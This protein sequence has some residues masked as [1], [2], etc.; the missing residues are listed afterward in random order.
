[1]KITSL[2]LLESCV[3]TALDYAREVEGE[4]GSYKQKQPWG[5]ILSVCIHIVFCSFEVLVNHSLG[6][7]YMWAIE[8]GYIFKTRWGDLLLHL[9]PFCAIKWPVGCQLGSAIPVYVL[10]LSAHPLL[11]NP[12][13]NFRLFM[14]STDSLS[15]P[16]IFFQLP[17]NTL[18]AADALASFFN[19]YQDTSIF[20]FWIA[21]EIEVVRHST[22]LQ[23]LLSVNSVWFNI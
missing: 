11:L 13:S 22:K 8:H 18:T 15:Q 9:N 20:F 3:L 4:K 6:G 12:I 7:A 10:P 2:H 14:S 16:F 1:M 19:T 17:N 5:K 21:L 23:H